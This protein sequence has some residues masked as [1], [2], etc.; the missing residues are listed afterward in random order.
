MS[1]NTGETDVGPVPGTLF[2]HP[3]GLAVL[4][5]ALVGLGGVIML[6]IGLRYSAAYQ[7]EPGS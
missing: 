3:R 1:T 4:G 6:V 7:V 5:A 2:G